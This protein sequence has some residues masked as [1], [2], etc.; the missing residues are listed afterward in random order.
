MN[1]TARTRARGLNGSGHERNGAEGGEEEEG[2]NYEV[3]EDDWNRAAERSQSFGGAEEGTSATTDN[4]GTGGV[5]LRVE[6]IRLVL[7]EGKSVPAKGS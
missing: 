6:Q 3:T 1:R 5:T 2:G 4:D 7:F